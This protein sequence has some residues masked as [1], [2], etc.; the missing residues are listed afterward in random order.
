MNLKNPIKILYEDD[1]YIVFDKPANLLV[2]PTPKNEE[3]TLVNIVNEQY[4]APN[5][6]YTLHPCHRLDRE[7]SGI[8]I[9][10]KGKKNQRLMMDE[11]KKRT[12]KKEYLTIVHGN[13]RYPHGEI[14]KPII[15]EKKEPALTRYTTIKTQKLYSVLK[16]YPIT[17]RT[18]QIRIHMSMIGH[19]ILGERKYARGK[20]HRLKFRR[21]AL[22][23]KRIEFLHP[24]THKHIIIECPIPKDIEEFLLRVR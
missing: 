16:V 1:Y 19:P 8:I 2:I 18:N 6:D 20:D 3:N 13:I 17:G 22:H 4:K 14:K 15:H 21:V 5:R 9:F 7:T 23:A 11:F 24:I 12:I 10:A